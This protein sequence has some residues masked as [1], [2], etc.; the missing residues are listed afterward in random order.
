MSFC[1]RFKTNL[2]IE[3]LLV[4][5]WRADIYLETYEQ[6][7]TS[8]D[9][10]FFCTQFLNLSNLFPGYCNNFDTKKECLYHD[11]SS[12]VN[13]APISDLNTFVLIAEVS[14]TG[15]KAGCTSQWNK[16]ELTCS[17]RQ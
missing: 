4:F 8:I 12:V 13:T 17:Q 5:T 14:V 7:S 6:T 1:W 16:V 15:S 10:T 9:L 3:V 11:I 2:C